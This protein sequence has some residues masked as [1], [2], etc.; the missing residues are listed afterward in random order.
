MKSAI[1]SDL[2]SLK[3]SAPGQ[4]ILQNDGLP[5]ELKEIAPMLRKLLEKL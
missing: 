4:A 5:E 1:E 2:I 3:S